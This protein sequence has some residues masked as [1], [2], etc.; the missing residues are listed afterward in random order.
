[1]GR[2]GNQTYFSPLATINEGNIDHLGFAWSYD[3]GT[4]RGQEASPI[5]VDGVMYTSGTWGFAYAVDAATG[6]E[7]WKFDP[8][9]D[10]ALRATHA[11]ISSIAAFRSGRARSL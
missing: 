2:D 9:A 6:K 7:I 1:M 11:A 3:L 8:Q 10:R 5:V 4:S